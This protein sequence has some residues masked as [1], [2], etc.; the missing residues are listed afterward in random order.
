MDQWANLECRRRYGPL[1]VVRAS[2]A[3]PIVGSYTKAM[4]AFRQTPR[5]VP[6]FYAALL[7]IAPSIAHGETT[8]E[9]TGRQ[10][11]AQLVGN[12]L[13]STL[14]DPMPDMQD[15]LL[16][17][18]PDNSAVW[19]NIGK[20]DKP[21]TIS[22]RMD[23]RE[24]LCLDDLPDPAIKYSCVTVKISGRDVILSRGSSNSTGQLIIRI[25]SGNPRGL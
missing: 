9:V 5:A 22:W 14:V 25:E 2:V 17:L 1:A 11:I 20:G 23:G 18:R 19:V 10:A 24:R 21:A 7:L 12:T 16:Y 13:V 3:G 15:G 6:W 8:S 4:I